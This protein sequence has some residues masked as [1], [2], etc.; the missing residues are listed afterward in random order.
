MRQNLTGQ[1]IDN[2]NQAVLDIMRRGTP[3]FSR[4]RAPILGLAAV[5]L[6][7][8]SSSSTTVNVV[9]GD[10]GTHSGGSNSTGGKSGNGGA[11]G[12]GGVTRTGGTTS[13]TPGANSATGGATI[14]IGGSSATLTGGLTATGGAVPA[15]GGASSAS[16]GTASVTG[17]SSSNGGAQTTF[18]TCPTGGA[19]GVPRTDPYTYG[20]CSVNAIPVGADCK[21]VV[22]L[23]NC[24]SAH[25]W[26][27]CR[28]CL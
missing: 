9:N 3:L 22:N 2:T 20:M 11:I 19:S 28:T 5:W 13:G 4:S 15:A 8:C 23:S 16:G 14:G 12:A 7:A 18:S 24:D 21:C 10:A 1:Y 6:A 17:G 26:C 25:Y 27:V